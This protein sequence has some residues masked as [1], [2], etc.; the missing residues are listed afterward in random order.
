MTKYLIIIIIFFSCSS[1]QKI[2]KKNYPRAI[3]DIT[4]IKSIDGDFERCGT[5]SRETTTSFMNS[6]YGTG[7]LK[8]N[9]EFSAIKEHIYTN[10]QSPNIK[11][12]TGF[13]TIRFLVNCKGKTGMFRI[14]ADD[15][16]FN[17]FKFNEQI[18]SQLLKAVKTLSEWKIL[19][20]NYKSFDYYQYL[21]I[22]IID[23]EIKEI[24][25]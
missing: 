3:G 6:Y 1:G 14:Y 12:Q 9:G 5:I 11:N 2:S 17:E 10:Y 15:L 18:T 13:L 4:Y 8:Y 21:T 20:Y 16:D 22:K 7:G 23:S 25:P 24:T 19:E